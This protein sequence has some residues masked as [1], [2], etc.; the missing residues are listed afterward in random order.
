MQIKKNLIHEY[1]YIFKNK[2]KKKTNTIL[3]LQ[4]ESKQT[5]EIQLNQQR[6]KL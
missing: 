1:F 5:V 3:L 4:L 2:V 6:I